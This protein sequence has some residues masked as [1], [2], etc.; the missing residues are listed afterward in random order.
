MLSRSLLLFGVL[1]CS[2]LAGTAHAGNP[3][4]ARNEFK[5]GIEAFRKNN[6]A[7][8]RRLLESAATTMESRALTYNLGVLYYKLGE[9]DLS[10][11]QFRKLLTSPQRALAF[12]NLGLVALAQGNE[13]QA[14]QA[15]GNAASEASEDKLESL[16]RARLTELGAPTPPRS[17]QGLVSLSAGYEDNIGLF[18]DSAPSSVDGHFLESVNALSATPLSREDDALKTTLHLY[19][20][21]YPGN[22]RFNIHLIRG[23]AAWQSSLTGGRFELGVGA[24]QLWQGNRSR[25]QRARLSSS[26]STRNC[27]FGSE[28]ALCRV[29]LEA[30]QVY[31]ERQYE[32]YNGQHYQLDAR[33]TGRTGDW[34]GRAGYRLEYDD[35][36]D[37]D[38]GNEFFS[39]S[40]LGQTLRLG[41]GYVFSPSLDIGTSLDYRLNYYDERHRLR[42]PEGLLVIHRKDHRL[43]L[44]IDGEYRITGDVSVLV[45]LQRS[46]NNSNINRYDYQR[47]T[48][49]LGVAV[50]L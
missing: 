31:A 19:G 7:Q 8:A 28:Q 37:F 21:E 16:A 34:R 41:L 32:A 44:S 20:R 36:S 2:G 12:Y 3:E 45:K 50:R 38:T 4:T 18:P 22:D 33:Y 48:A 24:D 25:E 26:I 43:T 42:V 15:F 1:L 17:W 35:R 47:Q 49:T 5:A 30:G 11:Q 14:R 9:L 6:L 10:E 27:N 39:V 40:P 29:A 13:E 23:A 46:D